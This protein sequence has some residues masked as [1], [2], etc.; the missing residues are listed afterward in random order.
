[1]SN[2]IAEMICEYRLKTPEIITAFEKIKRSDFLPDGIV[3][4][5]GKDF[6]EEYDAPIGIGLG[7]TNSQPRVI[8]FML[9]LLQPKRGNKV[10]DV[11]SGSGWQTALLCNV[12]DS[13]GFVYAIERIQKLKNFGEKNVGKY[14]FDNVKFICGDGSKGLPDKAPFDRIIVAASANEIP[15]ALKEQLK[16]GGRLV[17]PV[18]DSIKCNDNIWLLIKKDKDIF[19]EKKY[20][21]FIFVPLIEEDK[22]L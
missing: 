20:E 12:V 13:K 1:M 16:I 7:Q 17:I 10:L 5:K 2:L 8:A 15:K 18:R 4:S 14:G 9:E 11:G 21:N 19:E 6:I 22:N 3:E